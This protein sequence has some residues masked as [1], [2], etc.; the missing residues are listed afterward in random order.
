MEP[1]VQ[2]AY[3][4]VADDYARRF[5]DELAHKPLDR[6]LLGAFAE[7]ARGRGRVL[8]VGCGPGHVARHL[9]SLGLDAGGLDL[10]PAM[11]AVARGHAPALSFEVGDVRTLGERGL[12]GICALYVLC[13]LAPDELPRVAASLAGALAPGGWL[14]TGF[15]AAHEGPPRVHLDTWFGHAVSVDFWFH[16]LARVAGALASAGLS[17]EAELERRPYPEEYPSRRGYLLARRPAAQG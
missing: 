9:G 3:D 8:D 11:I 2:G 13:H 5:V 14:L 10:S 17:V 7:H 15:H 6:A 16:P 4:R 1:D 12:A